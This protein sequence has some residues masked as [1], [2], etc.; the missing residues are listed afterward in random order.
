M[1]HGVAAEPLPSRLCCRDRFGKVT[2]SPTETKDSATKES[3][4]KREIRFQ[5]LSEAILISLI[6]GLLCI[7]IGLAIP[8]SLR[9]LTA[10][11]RKG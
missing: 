4:T 7:L 1:A 6:G 10:Y 11:R 8:F 9:Y 3:A 2:V 5:F